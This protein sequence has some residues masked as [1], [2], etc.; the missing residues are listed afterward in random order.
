[1]S[2][3]FGKDD[4]GNIPYKDMQDYEQ[5]VNYIHF[6]PI[7]HGLVKEL[8]NWPYSSF[9]YY[10]QNGQLCEHWGGSSKTSVNDFG[11]GE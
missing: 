2:I 7:K 4:F 10:V 5:H 3:A 8:S 9:Y 1:M 6:N 11:F